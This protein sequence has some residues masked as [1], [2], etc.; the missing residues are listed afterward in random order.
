MLA[1][2]FSARERALPDVEGRH[3]KASSS[4]DAGTP[5]NFKENRELPP[6]S[7]P[8]LAFLTGERSS[9]FARGH[10]ATVIVP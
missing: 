6:G 7:T 4:I 1:P 10:P 5:C 9:V 3:L 2:Q 8:Y